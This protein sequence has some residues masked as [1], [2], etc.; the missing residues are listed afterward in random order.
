[1]EL[2]PLCNFP[3]GAELAAFAGALVTGLA[4]LGLTYFM[5]YSGVA[6]KTW[7]YVESIMPHAGTVKNYQDINAKLD[8]YLTDLARLEFTMD[9]EELAAFSHDLAVCNDDMQRGLMLKNE[10]AKRGLE[11][12]YAMGNAKSTRKWLASLAK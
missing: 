6:Q 10:I 5:L 9:V 8:R 12:P 2:L 7:T 11:L 1:V 3:F 4:T